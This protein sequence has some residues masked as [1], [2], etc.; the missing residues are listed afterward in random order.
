MA[1]RPGFGNRTNAGVKT[2]TA[3]PRPGSSSAERHGDIGARKAA[4]DV[5]IHA[6]H[7]SSR[8]SHLLLLEWW[9]EAK[10]VPATF[11]LLQSAATIAIVRQEKKSEIP[12]RWREGGLPSFARLTGRGA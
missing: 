1:V 8:L 9:R 3:C 4:D 7:G 11:A 6:D 12:A 10:I 5:D 2:A